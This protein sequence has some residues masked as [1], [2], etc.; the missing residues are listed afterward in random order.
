MQKTGDIF[1]T[2]S[3]VTGRRRSWG[4]SST[5]FGAFQTQCL[6]LSSF[7]TLMKQWSVSHLAVCDTWCQSSS[8]P[9]GGRKLQWWRAAVL[10]YLQV[11][12]FRLCLDQSSWACLAQIM[13]KTPAAVWLKGCGTCS[14]IQPMPCGRGR[15]KSLDEQLPINQITRRF[16]FGINLNS[17]KAKGKLDSLLK[18]LY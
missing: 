15:N 14:I 8:F 17:W 9:G 4:W 2:P 16:S 1:C 5:L 18:C 10:N 12:A 7:S 3:I 13:E 6:M 11:W